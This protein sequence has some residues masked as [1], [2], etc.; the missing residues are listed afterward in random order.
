MLFRKSRGSTQTTTTATTAIGAD[1]LLAEM[2][3]SGAN[4]TRLS[5]PVH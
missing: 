4:V 2:K 5:Q 1:E 3:D